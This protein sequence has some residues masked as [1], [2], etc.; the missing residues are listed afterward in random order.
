MLLGRSNAAMPDPCGTGIEVGVILKLV[1]TVKRSFSELGLSGFILAMS[2]D[3]RVIRV[4]SGTVGCT[5]TNSDEE[6]GMSSCRF[7]ED[8][9]PTA[10]AK[11]TCTHV[12][13]CYI[14]PR[15]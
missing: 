13:P 12:A 8:V 7:S 14:H 4:V 5:S 2:H 11:E 10:A 9:A 1:N 6:R 15:Q 3:F